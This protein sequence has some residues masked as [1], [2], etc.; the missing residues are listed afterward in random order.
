VWKARNP[1][2]F[3]MVTSALLCRRSTTPLRYSGTGS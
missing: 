2:D 3:L 1:Q